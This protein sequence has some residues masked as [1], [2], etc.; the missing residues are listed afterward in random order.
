MAYINKG[1]HDNP[2]KIPKDNLEGSL[3][4]VHNDYT[5]TDIPAKVP[6]EVEKIRIHI[7]THSRS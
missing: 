4:T 1:E 6:E 5:H 2:H 7:S 3:D